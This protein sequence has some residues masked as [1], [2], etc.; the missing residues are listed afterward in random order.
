MAL[1]G[2]V[3]AL[4]AEGGLELDGGDEEG[5]GFADRFE[6]TVHLDGS[7]AV[8]VAEYAAVHFRREGAASSPR[9]SMTHRPCRPQAWWQKERTRP[10]SCPPF[11]A[12]R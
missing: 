4:A 7:G 1:V 11:R 2:G 6:V 8:D 5:A 3:V 9:R 10:D 12:A